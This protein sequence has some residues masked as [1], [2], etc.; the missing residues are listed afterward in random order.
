MLLKDKKVLLTGA[1]RGIGRQIAIEMAKEGAIVIGVGRGIDKLNETAELVKKA[2][3]QMYTASMDIADYEEAR[4]VIVEMAEKTGGIDVLVNCAAIFK[5]A[6]FVDMTPDKWHETM[7]I[8]L[9]GVY[10]VTHI[11]IPYIIKAKGNVVNVVS[12]DAYYGCPGYSH[13]SAAKAGVI[14]FTRTLARELGS[15]GV[16]INCVA[17]GITETEMT[18]DRIEEGLQG[19]LDKLPIGRIGQ[20]VDIANAVIFMASDKAGFITGQVLHCNGGMYLG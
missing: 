9:T 6:Y 7:S 4:K 20:P 17:P 14:G 19:Y 16:R 12:Q 2:G 5:E 13:Y 3:G 10:N 8:D 11:S 1:G 15:E 18:K